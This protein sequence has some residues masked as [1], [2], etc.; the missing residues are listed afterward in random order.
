LLILPYGMSIWTGT[1][2]GRS[3]VEMAAADTF[4]GQNERPPS[5]CLG[6]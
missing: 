1:V 3:D 6:T 5:L 2:G 4:G